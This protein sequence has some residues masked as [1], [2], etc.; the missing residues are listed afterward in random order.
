MNDA[1]LE[2]YSRQ[3]LVPSFG[4][5][6]QEALARARVLLVGCG[7]LGNPAAMYLASAG[8]GYLRL[9]DDD[10]VEVSN[11][12]RQIAFTEGD[13]RRNKSE[14][15][16]AR[17][18]AL[19]SAVAIDSHVCR[20]DQQSAPMLLDSIDLVVDGS[21]SLETR[22][23]VN[24]E[25]A[26]R[27]LPWFMGAAVQFGG[28]NIAFSAS[29]E[30]GCYQCLAP[31]TTVAGGSCSELGVLGPVVASVAL[32]QVL[33]VIAYLSDSHKVPWGTLRIRDFAT[34]ET[35]SLSLSCRLD[36]PVCGDQ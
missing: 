27:K 11:L 20:F 2:R 15:L 5:E 13:V 10:V 18:R 29:R 33:D 35:Q 36:C 25:T 26:K 23:R 7:G 28:Q 24:V 16:A 3:I 31:D 22:Q 19:N 12:P 6:G 9:V 32:T 30:E 14:V 8:V 21:D 34:G 1:E 17:L 4:F